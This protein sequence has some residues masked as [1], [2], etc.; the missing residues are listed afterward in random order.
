MLKNIILCDY[1]KK[2]KLLDILSN[3]EQSFVFDNKFID[4]NCDTVTREMIKN[5]FKLSESYSNPEFVL[6][7]G[8]PGAGKS[9]ILRTRKD[10]L[11]YDINTYTYIDPDDLRLFSSGYR[12]NINGNQ[13][14][15][16]NKSLIKRKFIYQLP[17]GI[18]GKYNIYMEDGYCDIN[19]NFISSYKLM[20]NNLTC[21]IMVRDI[22]H[23]NSHFPRSLLGDCVRNKSNVIFSLT[24]DN[25]YF[26]DS[27]INYFV[28]N[29]YKIKIICVYTDKQTGLNRVKSRIKKDGRYVSTKYYNSIWDSLWNSKGYTIY[30]FLKK[31]YN[32]QN[33]IYI[34]N[35]TKLQKPAEIKEQQLNVVIY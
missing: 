34:D 7:V 18:F 35:N 8:H 28:E 23:G 3:I 4:T 29:K 32:Q 26:C 5:D 1:K 10:I 22:T 31:K 14:Y 15:N 20:D 19:N 16:N 13:A 12:K 33:V 11:S 9:T 6:M 27:I 24:C 17:T 25:F 21:R 2:N 30:D